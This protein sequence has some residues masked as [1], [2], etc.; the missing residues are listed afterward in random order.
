V[1]AEIERQVLQYVPARA[2]TTMPQL[3]V[4]GAATILSEFGVLDDYVPPRQVLKLGRMNMME[5]SRAASCRAV[6]GRGK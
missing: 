2:L 6:G 4:I 3:G 5:K 1:D